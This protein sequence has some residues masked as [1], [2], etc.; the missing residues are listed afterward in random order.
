MPILLV[1]LNHRTAPVELRE[2][3]SLEGYGLS[4]AL[5][6][7]PVHASALDGDPA[8]GL[9]HLPL[10]LREGVILS[11]CNRLELYAVAG[12]IAGGRAATENFLSRLQGIPLSHLKP[13]LYFMHDW[14]VVAHLMR[15]AAGLD[16]MILG[17]PQILGQ[18]ASAYTAAKAASTTGPLLSQ[19]FAQAIHSGKRVRTK[20]DIS[21]HTTSVSHAAV[22]LAE[23]RLGGLAAFRVLVVGGGE[24][25]ELALQALAQRGAAH[26][27]C[28]NRT[29]SRAMALAEQFNGEALAWRQLDEALSWADVVVS[30]T[31]APHTVIHVDDVAGALPARQGRPLTFIDLAVP[32]DVEEQV[33]ALPGVALFD[34]DSLQATLDEHLAQREAAIPQ[35][36]AII[37]EEM[38]RFAAWLSSREVTPVIADLRAWAKGVAQAEVERAL[39]R[40]PELGQHEREVVEMLAHRLVNKLLHEPTTRLKEQAASGDGYLA[41]HLLRELFA[42]HNSETQASSAPT[43]SSGRDRNLREPTAAALQGDSVGD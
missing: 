32:R 28:V 11:T 15:V 14:E 33:G 38:D 9:E 36:E 31:G 10:A 17:E 4:M 29:H 6:E 30:A 5:E 37:A 16:S 3:L 41:A 7:M 27:T 25:A 21:Q 34:I 43:P 18:V 23:Q 20:T 24:M 40:L 42:L 1:G 8:L 13:Y 2:K 35:V 26:L 12:Q 19:L 22:S 39:N